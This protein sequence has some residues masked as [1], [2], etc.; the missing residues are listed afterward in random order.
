MDI[1]PNPNVIENEGSQIRSLKG[2]KAMEAMKLR[3]ILVGLKAESNGM[4]LTRNAPSCTSMAKALTG[5]KTRDRAKLAHA[6]QLKLEAVVAECLI[7]DEEDK[8]I[9]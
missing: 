1:K 6:I 9:P 7:V 4:R 8:Q 2:P 5:L 3:T